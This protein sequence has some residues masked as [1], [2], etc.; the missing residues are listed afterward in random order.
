MCGDNAGGF[1]ALCTLGTEEP[2]TQ[3]VGIASMPLPCPANELGP[4]A[5]VSLPPASA[6]SA[7]HV[8]G[9]TG[10]RE[11]QDQASCTALTAAGVDPSTLCLDIDVGEW[12]STIDFSGYDRAQVCEV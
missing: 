8:Q 10:R 11:M 1:V 3:P 7:T 5:Q 4:C 6:T 2:S 9:A 12:D